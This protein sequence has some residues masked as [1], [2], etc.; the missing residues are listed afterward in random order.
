[1]QK[2]GRREIRNEP[3]IEVRAVP[4]CRSI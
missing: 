3:K 4:V 2:H 1:M